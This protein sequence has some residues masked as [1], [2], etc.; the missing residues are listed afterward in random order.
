MSPASYLT[1]PPRVA[2][3]IVAMFGPAATI[4][5]V[6]SWVVYGALI[7]S[8]LVVAGAVVF[9]AR[10]LLDGWRA[11][12]SLRR[13]LAEELHRLADLGELTVE[14]TAAAS[15]TARLAATLGR[16]R[17]TLARFAVLRTAVDEVQDG[18]GRVTAV[19]PRK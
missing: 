1:A 4:R 9:L 15:D 13:H 19:Y 16:L 10:R 12:K 18:L 6:S 7:V 17:P 5:G 8:F 2:A 11:L 14:K 3:S